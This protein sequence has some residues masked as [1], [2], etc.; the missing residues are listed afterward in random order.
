MWVE[1]RLLEY[2]YLLGSSPIKTPRP[3]LT[4]P[5]TENK[6]MES[7]YFCRQNFMIFFLLVSYG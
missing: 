7:G 4:T 6:Y 2:T 1:S 5:V 3:Q